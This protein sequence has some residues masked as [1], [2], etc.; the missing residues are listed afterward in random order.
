MK[1]LSIHEL[2]ILTNFNY[3]RSSWSGEDTK[4]IKIEYDHE[5]KDFSVVTAEKTVRKNRI[6]K[7]QAEITAWAEGQLKAFEYQ[8][9]MVNA[10]QLTFE[11]DELGIELGTVLPSTDDNEK[12]TQMS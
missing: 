6:S 11:N 12:V 8:G 3:A 7:L 5:Y 9:L 10:F 2:N 4:T 1:K